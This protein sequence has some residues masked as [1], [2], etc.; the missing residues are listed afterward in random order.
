MSF[1]HIVTSIL[2]DESFFFLLKLFFVLITQI[3]Q[4][5]HLLFPH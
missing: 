1:V 5:V 2:V 3:L 4:F